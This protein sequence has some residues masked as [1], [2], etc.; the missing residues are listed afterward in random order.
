M[1]RIAAVFCLIVLGTQSVIG[2]DYKPSVESTADINVSVARKHARTTLRSLQEEGDAGASRIVRV[3]Y[4]DNS[5][6]ITR[7]AITSQGMEL[8]LGRGKSWGSRAGT[9]R[10]YSIS[11]RDIGDLAVRP[12]G[13]SRSDEVVLPRLTIR[14]DA[15]R[16]ARAFA[17][18]LFV[19]SQRH[20]PRAVGMDDREFEAMVAKYRGA[21]AKPEFPESA[22][23]YRVQA[24][25]A[26]RDK[27][28]DE[29]ADFYAE[30]LNLAPWWPEGRFNRALILG[31]LKEYA[32]AAVEMKRYLALVPEAGNARAAQDKIY[33]W[34]GRVK[35]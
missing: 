13:G 35:R 28:F 12:K 7:S 11:W 4:E 21:G 5:F 33:E 32:E 23:R 15:A 2:Q 19:L 34:E 10:K 25:A 27:E 1:P 22:R 26:V 3:G 30:A 29:A 20:V 17:D 24:E 6:D 18:A 9:L 31:E 16:D 8:D 14:F